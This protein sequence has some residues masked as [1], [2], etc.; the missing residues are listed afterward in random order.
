VVRSKIDAARAGYLR[1]LAAARLTAAVELQRAYDQ[2]VQHSRY[3]GTVTAAHR[4][5][6]RDAE[7]RWDAV[8]GGWT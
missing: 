7:A 5:R 3:F 4:D 6:I 1:S 2:A 8:R